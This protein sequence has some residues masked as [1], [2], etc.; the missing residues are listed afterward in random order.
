[1]ASFFSGIGGLDLGLERT[2]FKLLFHCEIKPFCRDI[3][4]QH[5]PDLPLEQ[6]IRK[7][8]DASIPEADVWAAGFPCQ[9]LSLAR[10]GPRSG[11]RGQQSGLFHEFMRLVRE[12]RPRAVVLENVHGL[13]SS[14]GGRDFAIVLQALDELGYGVAWRVLNSKDFGVPQQRR[15]VYIVAMHR[16]LGGPGQVLF[17]PQCGDWNPKAGRSNGPKSPSLFQ[18]IIGDP[19][20]GPLVKSLAHCIYAESARHTGTDW[21]RNY[22]WYPD[23][24]VRRFTPNEVERVQGFPVDWTL[25]RG[26]SDQQA[27][28]IDSLRYHAIGN[29]VTPPVAEWVGARLM[30]VM[31]EQDVEFV[32]GSATTVAAE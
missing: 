29:A 9:D 28:R 24:R 19:V 27:D 32:R 25:P 7:L 4:Q 6:D 8:D 31:R 18:T 10:M 22:V 20:K 12:R 3:L 16:D 17:E 2:G 1:M 13:L 11:L 21:S 23:G 26:M 15:R 30:G 14:H 5:W